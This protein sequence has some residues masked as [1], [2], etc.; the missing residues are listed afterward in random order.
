MS[1]RRKGLVPGAAPARVLKFVR[2]NPGTRPLDICASL[3]IKRSTVEM[4]ICRLVQMKLYVRPVRMPRQ[5][6][7]KQSSPS[8]TE[9]LRIA[10]AEFS[11]TAS[12]GP[13]LLSTSAPD[14]HP[15]GMRFSVVDGAMRT[16]SGAVQAFAIAGPD[17]RAPEYPGNHV[18]HAPQ[19][20][21]SSGFGYLGTKRG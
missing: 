1:L 12:I 11:A 3:G 6:K 7:P 5:V 20:P 16:S 21:W 15:T 18:G 9:S 14:A 19:S 2:R 10:R 8:P 17:I 4:A 13:S